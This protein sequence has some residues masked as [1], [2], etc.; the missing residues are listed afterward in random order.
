MTYEDL[1]V[2]NDI[3]KKLAERG[4]KSRL[5]YLY[6][7][8]FHRGMVT[9]WAFEKDIKEE[10]AEANILVVLVYIY[11]GTYCDRLG[12]ISSTPAMPMPPEKL[13]LLPVVSATRVSP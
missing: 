2:F 13:V 3:N 9:E 6:L 4:L 12:F 1:Q 7:S 10:A 5:S 8:G 11:P